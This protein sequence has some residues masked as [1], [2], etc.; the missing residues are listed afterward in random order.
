MVPSLRISFFLKKTQRARK[1]IFIFWWRHRAW[2]VL[3]AASFFF[4]LNLL[5][6]VSGLS[7]KKK[8][9]NRF[10]VLHQKNLALCEKEK[11]FDKKI[12]FLKALFPK[13]PSFFERAH[14]VRYIKAATK[15]IPIQQVRFSIQPNT[16]YPTPWGEV[17]KTSVKLTFFMASDRDVF[18]WIKHL[19]AIFSGVSYGRV[20]K[21]S[22]ANT[23]NTPLFPVK[24]EYE[25]EWVRWKVSTSNDQ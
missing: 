24:G 18:V 15:N 6:F 11:L 8:T 16:T 21:I 25:F 12:L 13:T 23:Q 2:V 3:G 22:L 7:L 14:V 20:L 5:F 4:I 1:K 9:F 19:H 10:H 17:L